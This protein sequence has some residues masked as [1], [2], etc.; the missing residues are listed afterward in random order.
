[1]ARGLKTNSEHSR[2][3][4]GACEGGVSA[5][6][7]LGDRWGVLEKSDMA[8]GHHSYVGITRLESRSR[9]SAVGE[10]AKISWRDGCLAAFMAVRARYSQEDCDS[11][12]M[13]LGVCWP[14]ACGLPQPGHRAGSW[15][16][17]E[18]DKL[19]NGRAIALP[20]ELAVVNV[21]SAS[22]QCP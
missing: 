8:D 12:P 6:D 15:E 3:R 22:K 9:F 1:M 13:C 11:A 5:A 2:Q 10:E 14:D 18:Y 20:V 21:M 16:L 7:S 17:A 19:P 4:S